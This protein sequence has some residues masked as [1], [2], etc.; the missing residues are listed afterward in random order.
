MLQTRLFLIAL[1]LIFL[2]NCGRS[3]KQ[4][5]T[6]DMQKESVSHVE[7]L[8]ASDTLLRTPE[9]VIYDDKTELIYVTNVNEKPW[10][11]DGNGFVS[12]LD[13]TGA[14]VN[15]KWIEGLDG[16][17]GMAIVNG[18][19]FVADIDALVEIDIEKGEIVSTI[20]IEGAVNLNDVTNYNGAIYVS[21]SGDDAVYKY[22]DGQMQKIL[23]DLATRP[24]GLRIVDGQLF[25]A[26]SGTSK[27]QKID[28]VTGTRDSITSGIGHGDGIMETNTPNSFVV[29]GWQ[30]Q[31]YH[32]SPDKGLVNLIDTKDQNINSADIWLIKESNTLLVPTFF[33]NRVVAYKLTE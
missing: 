11:K 24:N 6:E 9:S 8:W 29:S 12:Q 21:D 16:P 30:G 19:L 4:V 15:L 28:L 32:Y 17:K 14:L 10:E 13:I 5:K 3:K 31:V 33:D 22:E 2:T 18:H 23:T 26:Y 27:L 7:L 20:E 1:A 25:V